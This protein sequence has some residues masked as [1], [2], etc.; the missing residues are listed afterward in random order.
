MRRTMTMAM[1]VF[2]VVSGS[3]SARADGYAVHGKGQIAYKDAQTAPKA[4]YRALRH[5]RVRLMD[6]DTGFDEEIA[7]GVTDASGHFDLSGHAE[8]WCCGND[9]KPDPYIEIVLEVDGWVDVENI[10]GFSYRYDSPEHSNTE[11]SIDFG[12]LLPE[13]DDKATLYARGTEQYD[14][15]RQTA[16]GSIPGYD[17]HVQIDVPAIFEAGTPWTT[18]E[19]IHWPGDFTNF[20]GVYHEFGH[21]IREA[22]DGGKLHFA[23]DA[24][25]FWYPRHHTNTLISNPGFAFNEG[26]AEYHSTLLGVHGK[27]YDDFHDTFTKW[28][29]HDGGDA[30]EGN[31]AHKLLLIS[32]ACG[33]FQNL[34]S[35][36]RGAGEDAIHS[37]AEFHRAF[38]KKFPECLKKVDGVAPVAGPD[39]AKASAAPASAAATGGGPQVSGGAVTLVAQLA[40]MK[41]S[42][43]AIDARAPQRQPKQKPSIAS[44]ATKAPQLAPVLTRVHAKRVAHL[45]RLDATARAAYRTSVLGLKPMTFQTL[46]DGSW[47]KDIVAARSNFIGAVAPPLLAD[48]QAFRKDLVTERAAASDAR[49]TK[50]LDKVAAKYARVEREVQAALASRG[51]NGKIPEVLMPKTFHGSAAPTTTPIP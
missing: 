48:V 50:Y 2:S 41:R 1:A 49:L 22:A 28:G 37:Y 51:A 8:D 5:A 9:E 10:I 16:G 31:V 24:V 18:P 19:A 38:G 14:Y 4:T 3:V 21:R 36:L 11:G 15:Y 43:D 46:K 47:E 23:W 32:N 39:D 25:R 6:S 17:G 34:W 13:D 45:Q 40:A 29:A 42:V 12:T 44:L 30:C 27:P 7:Q 20:D 26:W 33:G 35:V